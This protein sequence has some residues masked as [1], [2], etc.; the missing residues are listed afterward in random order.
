MASPRE[1]FDKFAVG[2]ASKVKDTAK[3]IP[4]GA[5]DTVVKGEESLSS[6]INKAKDFASDSVSKLKTWGGTLLKGGS[7]V[8][9]PAKK[10][11]RFEGLE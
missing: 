3:A 7:P 8:T 9:P 4:G 1:T 11:S 2:A 5:A 6:G 10:K